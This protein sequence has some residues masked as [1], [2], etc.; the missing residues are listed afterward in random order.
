MTWVGHAAR[1]RETRNV[2]DILVGK[3]EGKSALERLRSKWKDDIR[4]NLREIG[5]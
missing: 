4:M 1:M 3:S 2:Y 5:W